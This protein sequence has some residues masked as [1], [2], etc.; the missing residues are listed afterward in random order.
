[1]KKVL[2]VIISLLLTTFVSAQQ[3]ARLKE[4]NGI[5]RLIVDGKPFIMLGGELHNST[6]STDMYLTKTWNALDSMHVN[7]VIATI[8]WEQLEPVEGKFDF[9]LADRII[10]LAGQHSMHVAIVW[11][12]TWKN[13]ESSYAPMWVKENVRRFARVK[14]SK[15][16]NTTTLSPFCEATCKADQQ[17]FSQLMRHIKER[18]NQR[19]VVAIQVE[20]EMGAFVDLDYSEEAKR[21][22]NGKVPAELG[23][24]GTWRQ[25][26]SDADSMKQAFMSWGFASY[27]DKVAAAGK[28]VYDL[29]MFVNTWLVPF[30]APLG[31]FPNGGPIPKAFD[32]WKA[33]GRHIDILSPDIY[34]PQFKEYADC[35]TR[36]NNPLFIPETV[37]DAAPAFY[38]L[39]EKN[40]ICYSSF[41]IEDAYSD[42]FYVGTYGVIKE[43]LPLISKYQG[44][45]HMH[46]FFRQGDQLTDSVRFGNCQF[47]ISYIKPEKSGFGLI[48]Q[49][50]DNE[51]IVAGFGAVIKPKSLNDKVTVQF[52]Q[53]EEG[54]FDSTSHWTKTCLLNGDQTDNNKSLYLRGRMKFDNASAP[55]PNVAVS[56]R[57]QE[58]ILNYRRL[59]GVYKVSTYS[60]SRK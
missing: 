12:G 11:F 36:K 32:I 41:A 5:K 39:A 57:E 49:T 17:A 45:D 21:L 38:A 4:V 9:S 31:T 58:R 56:E 37:R 35:Y 3:S 7:S 55:M 44:T 51:F 2:F 25:A 48:I 47:D 50:G 26:Y 6:S 53:I 60:Y 42:Y 23:K 54:K 27:T 43:L 18:D 29:P 8:S 33:V 34:A 40:A 28:S 10:E 13:G 14:N 16:E 59:P 24:H 20:N 22:L 30:E 46:G 1:M 19:R 52:G 15:G